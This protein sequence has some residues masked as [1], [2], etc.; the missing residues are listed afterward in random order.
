MTAELRAQQMVDDNGLVEA[1]I[2]CKKI[3]AVVHENVELDPTGANSNLL[4]YWTNVM[5]F[6]L[7]LVA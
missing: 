6:L 4:N 5:N 7:T 2:K 3:L 1:M